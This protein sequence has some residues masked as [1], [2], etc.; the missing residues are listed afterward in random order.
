M[1]ATTNTRP[2][3]TPPRIGGK[4]VPNVPCVVEVDP[5]TASAW[6][7]HN[8]HN[9]SMREDAVSALARDMAAGRW[10]YTGESVKFSTS[11]RLL[12]GQHRLAAIVQAKV[13]VPILVVPGLPDEA[14]DVMDTG[15]KRTA[16]DVL[17]LAG[18]L[19][20][21]LLAAAVRLA[22]IYERG[23]LTGRIQ[24]VTHSEV[25]GWLSANPAIRDAVAAA[26]N[27]A[28]IP[29]SG[30]MIAFGL[31]RL[32]LVDR[33]AADEFFTD[34]AQMRTEG[35]GDPRAA[36]LQRLNAARS[37]RENLTRPA[38]VSLLFRAWNAVR[39]GQPVTLL[40]VAYS[41]GAVDI[42]QPV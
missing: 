21:T 3:P 34:L 7:Q 9:R 10:Q 32:R 17:D 42:P 38:Q 13:A 33:E 8:T 27:F 2:K 12:D 26:R 29:L 14:Q 25:L 11:G 31:W 15:A 20:P 19:N 24:Q 36:L 4:P 16:S 23:N 18:E 6:L 41:G 35:K 28:A 37:S 22:I 30:A 40:K 39:R 5:T 1:T